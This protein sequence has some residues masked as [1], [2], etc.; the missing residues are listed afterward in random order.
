LFTTA[1]DGVYAFEVWTADAAGNESAKRSGTIYI[2]RTP[3]AQIAAER[4]GEDWID[5]DDSRGF[6]RFANDC[7]SGLIV[8]SEAG[9]AGALS[10]EY[11]AVVTGDPASAEAPAEGWLSLSAVS[12]EI[13][14]E[15]DFR[16]LFFIRVTD[17]AGNVSL[18][19]TDGMI[20]EDAAPEIQCTVPALE[21][22][23]GW[24]GENPTL[25]VEVDETGTIMSG[26][27]SVAIYE[28]R[29]DTVIRQTLLYENSGDDLME[30]FSGEYTTQTQGEFEV[31]V[32]AAD[33]A[34]NISVGERRTLKVDA[35]DPEL[36]VDLTTSQG[37][38]ASDTWTNRNVTATLSA[39]NYSSGVSFSY[40]EDGGLSWKAISGNT[41]YFRDDYNESVIF[42]AQTLGGRGATAERRI[43]IQKTI[44]ELL[45]GFLS[46]TGGTLFSLV[47]SAAANSFNWRNAPFEV[48]ITAPYRIQRIKSNGSRRDQAPITTYYTLARGI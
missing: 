39:R 19:R 7:S 22:G 4:N 30:S 33:R 17:N 20:I 36:T 25:T 47:N 45:S 12:P 10:Y 44:P 29:G 18:A 34:G 9:V 24:Y 31:Y 26:L 37:V 40:S 28:V 41:V 8:S 35:A 6:E 13:A 11:A 15:D 14:L 16:G 2:D 5:A 21:A 32:L 3:P 1:A 48:S 46:E 38:Y 23:L 43:K 42:R 27:S